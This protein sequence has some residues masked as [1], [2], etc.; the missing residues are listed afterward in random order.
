MR[1]AAAAGQCG[2]ARMRV[3]LYAW[4]VPGSAPADLPIAL[5]ITDDRRH[6]REASEQYLL[7][8]GN[9]RTA[10]IEEVVPGVAAHRFTPFYVRTGLAWRGQQ[11]ASGDVHWARV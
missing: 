10:V 3:V 9:A 7:S 6:A 11:S 1:A 4:T 5:G 2:Y 8:G